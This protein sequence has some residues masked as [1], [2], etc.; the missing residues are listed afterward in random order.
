M[1]STALAVIEGLGT[2]LGQVVVATHADNE[3]V[4]LARAVT[5]AQV[6]DT[7]A[8]THILKVGTVW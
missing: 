3:T 8:K 6:L 4:C 1:P 2:R 5:M 7:P